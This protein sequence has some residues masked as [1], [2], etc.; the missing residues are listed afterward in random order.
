[1]LEECNNDGTYFETCN[2]AY[3]WCGLGSDEW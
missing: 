3:A 1:M 2:I